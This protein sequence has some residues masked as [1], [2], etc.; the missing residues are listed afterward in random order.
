[1]KRRLV[2]VPTLQGTGEL[3]ACLRAEH[4]FNWRR[5]REAAVPAPPLRAYRHLEWLQAQ[6]C[7][8]AEN[9]R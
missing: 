3:R 2:H 5:K 4:W 8:P 7:P 6:P 1:M 9:C